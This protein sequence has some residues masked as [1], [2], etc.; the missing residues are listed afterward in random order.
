MQGKVNEDRNGTNQ[1]NIKAIE[2][3]V[4]LWRANL[5]RTNNRTI[6]LSA[7]NLWHFDSQHHKKSHNSRGGSG[8]I[9]HA[10][11]SCGY[12][13]INAEVMFS[14]QVGNKHNAEDF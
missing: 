5:K 12:I 10:Y 11:H 13:S 4:C 7:S 3:K 2:I 14:Q 6:C 1:P 8:M 9:L